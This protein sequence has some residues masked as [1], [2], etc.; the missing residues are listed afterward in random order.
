M[1]RYTPSPPANLRAAN[2]SFVG[3]GSQS[4]Q[5]LSRSAAMDEGKAL[6]RIQAVAQGR[7]TRKRLREQH[8]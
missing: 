8:Q 5:A 2:G 3:T 1:V 6:A 4:P 7:S